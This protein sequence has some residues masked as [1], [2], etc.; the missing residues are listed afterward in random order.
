MSLEGDKIFH[1]EKFNFFKAW[2]ARKLMSKIRKN[3]TISGGALIF[4]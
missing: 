4:Y 2:Y 3:T 1:S